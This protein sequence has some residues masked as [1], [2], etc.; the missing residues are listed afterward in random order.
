M[1]LESLSYTNP[2]G[3][4]FCVAVLYESV[5]SGTLWKH[6]YVK[7]SPLPLKINQPPPSRF[8][9]PELGEGVVSP[10]FQKFGIL[11]NIDKGVG[12]NVF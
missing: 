8:L 4:S 9:W 2:I 12:Q 11:L 6:L 1:L 7:M 10:A 3:F 5:V